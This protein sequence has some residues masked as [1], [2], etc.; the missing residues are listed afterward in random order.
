MCKSFFAAVIAAFLFVFSAGAEQPA[1]PGAEGYG[2]YA[3]GGRGGDVYPVTNLA[4][5][6]D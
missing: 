3:S 5:Y 2:A 1:F 6:D 4:D